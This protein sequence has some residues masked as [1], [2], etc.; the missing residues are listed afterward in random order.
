M[1]WIF[2][3]SPPESLLLN[4]GLALAEAGR[5][6]GLFLKIRYRAVEPFG[7][8]ERRRGGRRS[9]PTNSPRRRSLR[10]GA[11]SPCPRGE[12]DLPAKLRVIRGNPRS[13]PTPASA[14]GP[15][16]RGSFQRTGARTEPERLF[17][18]GGLRWRF[19]RAKSARGGDRQHRRRRRE[20]RRLS[21][22]A[23]A[24]G[25]RGGR[26]DHPGGGENLPQRRAGRAPG[27]ASFARSPSGHSA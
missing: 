9:R 19:P 2:E 5:H 22:R 17:E 11:R 13:I 23:R 25:R 16:P 27:D 24:E 6:F 1:R 4:P 15:K 7:A 20:R 10:A 3:P 18:T 21:R 8:L 14:R 12:V 26:G